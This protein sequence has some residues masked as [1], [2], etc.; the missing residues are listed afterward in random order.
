MRKI[1]LSIA[2]AC[3]FN[4]SAFAQKGG[5]L[6][7]TKTATPKPS[8][9]PPAQHKECVNKSCKVVNGAG[10][11]KCSSDNDCSKLGCSLGKCI[12]TTLTDPVPS[13]TTDT[14]CKA[15]SSP[16][17]SPAVCDETGGQ[18][19]ANSPTGSILCLPD[20]P[21]CVD[22]ARV[23]CES[24]LRALP[25]TQAFAV[26]IR[27]RFTCQN[28]VILKNLNEFG[29]G[30][31]G[32]AITVYYASDA[33]AIRQGIHVWCAKEPQLPAGENGYGC[34]RSTSAA[35]PQVPQSIVNAVA[36]K[37]L[38]KYLDKGMKYSAQLG[39]P[40][41]YPRTV[42]LPNPDLCRC[43]LKHVE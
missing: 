21:T 35:N 25:P 6:S 4:S 14:D 23:D 20:S 3:C 36:R 16:S 24:Y 18:T 2:F 10:S 15:L 38:S 37:V 8:T 11:D 9:A 28:S 26:G 30:I 43:K 27:P 19:P 17:P 29:T 22:Y 34:W 5:Y 40:C 33:T 12:R 7:P 1:I 32:H 42:S 41:N 13:C 31:A 39:D